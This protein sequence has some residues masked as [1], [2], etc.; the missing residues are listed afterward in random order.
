MLEGGPGQARPD[1]SAVR[2]RE[3]R[4][5]D[6]RDEPVASH[7]GPDG[8]LVFHRKLPGA[9]E[10]PRAARPPRTGSHGP[11]PGSLRVGLRRGLGDGSRRRLRHPGQGHQARRQALLRRRHRR[12]LERHPRGRRRRRHA[13]GLCVPGA[14]RLARERRRM[15]TDRRV[16]R[17]HRRLPTDPRPPLRPPGAPRDQPRAPPRLPQAR[18][19]RGGWRP[20]RRRRERP[21]RRWWWWCFESPGPPL[22]F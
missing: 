9:P 20:P 18:R 1:E 17:P 19:R 15:A 14:G 22:F 7:R 5:V 3:G 4:R 11:P 8:C 16:P 12:H 2:A 21:F 10:H 13:R 6:R